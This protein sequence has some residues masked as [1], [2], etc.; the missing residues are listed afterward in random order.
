L[1]K[2]KKRS[3]NIGLKMAVVTFELGDLERLGI[4]Q[5]ELIKVVDKLGMSLEKIE[6]TT[7]FIDITPNRP[8]MLDII[9][10]TRAACYLLGKKVPK[11]KAYSIKGSPITQVMVTGNVKKIQPFIVA[12]VVKNVDLKGNNLKN[13]VNFTEKFC[14]TYGRKRKK[15]SMGIYDY[16]SIKGPITYDASFEDEFIPLGSTKKMNLNE[17]LKE[18][19]QGEEYSH[20]LGKAQK[21]PVLKDQKGILAL[22]PIVNS[23]NTKI[24]QN[25]KNLFIDMT[26]STRNAAEH[27]LN[28][29]ACSFIDMGADVYSCEIIYKNKKEITPNLEY[30]EIKVKRTKAENTIGFWMEDNK[31]INLVNK[32]GYPAAKYGNHTIVYVPPFRL[33]VLND[34]D[35]IEDIAIAYGYENIAPMPILAS[36]IG[37]PDLLKE[38]INKISVFMVGLGFSEAMNTYLTNKELNFEKLGRKY[39]AESTIQVAYAKTESIT[40]LRTAILPSLMDNLS[41]SIHE[42]MPQRLFEIDKAFILKDGNVVEKTNI[43]VVNEHSRAN[44]SEI[45]SVVVQLLNMLDFKNYSI[46]ELEDPAFIKGRSAG[47]ILNN[48]QIGKFGEIHPKV[49]E[50]F[51][52]EEPVVA[53]EINLGKIL[54]IK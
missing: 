29:M 23:D 10:F 30:K 26:A 53:A 14:D 9:G 20:I 46:K 39:D 40:M 27:G 22:I 45:K 54:N 13:L 24:T 15:I 2:E 21:Y 38:Q 48:E 8:D 43:A 25:T 49:L 41:R 47:I 42:K 1:A 5:E 12:M 50:N 33:D 44:F 11:E 16:D 28:L 35:I 7:V 4:S 36:V 31:V 18:T 17:I 52:L 3:Q 51:K 32:L 6:N 34:Q 37:E 19:P